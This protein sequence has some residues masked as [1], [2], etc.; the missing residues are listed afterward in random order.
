MTGHSVR[1]TPFSFNTA[2]TAVEEILVNSYGVSPLFPYL[3]DFLTL[4]L[5]NSTTCQSHVDIASRG[6]ICP[7]LKLNFLCINLSA[8]LLGYCPRKWL[9]LCIFYS[10]ELLRSGLI[11]ASLNH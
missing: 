5:V 9:V 10:P 7:E 6:F 8:R 2:A 4:E 11:I 3:D 1:S